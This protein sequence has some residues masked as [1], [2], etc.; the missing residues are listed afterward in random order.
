M[1]IYL[2]FIMGVYNIKANKKRIILSIVS[3]NLTRL[4]KRNKNYCTVTAINNLF[5]QLNIIK[6]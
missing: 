3:Q 2:K 1:R 5:N 4:F 6:F